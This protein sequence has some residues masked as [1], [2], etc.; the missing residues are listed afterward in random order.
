MA[1][2]LLAASPDDEVRTIV[3]TCR[4]HLAAAYTVRLGGL[5]GVPLLKVPTNEW[6]TLDLDPRACFLLVHVDNVSTFEMILDV[7]GMRRHEAM[8]LL[9]ELLDRGVIAL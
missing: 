1:D 6:L 4:G 9:W 2:A 3:E 5:A 8:R 7:S